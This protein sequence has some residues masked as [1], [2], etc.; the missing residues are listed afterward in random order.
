[1]ST[2][3]SAGSQCTSHCHW[4]PVTAWLWRACLLTERGTLTVTI[5]STHRPSFKQNR[6]FTARQSHLVAAAARAGGA[7]RAP[8]ARSYILL[9]SL[10]H[11][12]PPADF[13]RVA[14]LACRRPGLGLSPVWPAL[15]KWQCPTLSLGLS[16]SAARASL[17]PPG[18]GSGPPRAAAATVLKRGPEMAG[19]RPSRIRAGMREAP[20]RFSPARGRRPTASGTGSL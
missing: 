8:V 16:K 13:G 2:V 11:P 3:R 20:A 5:T 18:P 19:S 1:M 4:L 12:W 15:L 14:N 7:H 17:P 6:C 10:W 9:C